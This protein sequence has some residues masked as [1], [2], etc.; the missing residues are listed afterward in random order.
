MGIAIKTS[1]G[2]ITLRKP[3]EEFLPEQLA[4]NRFTLLNISAEHTFR[5][6][7]MPLHHRDPFDRM[8]IVQSKIEGMPLISVD[9]LFDLYE[10]N[11]VW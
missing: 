9:A 11:R 10:V 5:I 1:L 2:K 7:R 8:L 6:V 3:L 4:S